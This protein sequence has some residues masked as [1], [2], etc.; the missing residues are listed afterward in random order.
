MLFHHF[1]GALFD[2]FSFFVFFIFHDKEIA[3]VFS[4]TLL[5]KLECMILNTSKNWISFGGGG[6]SCE[7]PAF[8]SVA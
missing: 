4:I 7:N 5:Q 2:W 1:L 3:N 6:G 8:F